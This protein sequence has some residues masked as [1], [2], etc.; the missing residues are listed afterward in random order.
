[1][2]DSRHQDLP[3]RGS[4]GCHI[5]SADF[6]RI[7]FLNGLL[8]LAILMFESSTYAGS[9][10]PQLAERLTCAAPNE[11]SSVVIEVAGGISAAELNNYLD[12][13][14]ETLSDRRREGAL[15]L[16]ERA[17]AT[18]ADLLIYLHTLEETG[19]V[20]NI[21][22]HWLTNTI[23]VEMI[24]CNIALAAGRNDVIEVF[25]YPE[26]IPIEPVIYG[27]PAPL[28]KTKG[29]NVEENLK[30]IGADSAWRMGYTGE[31]RIV[32]LLDF[33]GVEGK[34]PALFDNW[35]G[36]DGNPGAA[37]LGEWTDDGFPATVRPNAIHGTHIVGIM[38]G[39]D[40]ATGDTIGVAP[41]AEWI[42]SQEA[43][44]EF[45]ADPDGNPY[46][47]DDVPDVINIS[48]GT[49]GYCWDRYWDMIDMT[50]AFGIVNIISA[51]NRGSDPYS[52]ES[53]G[54]RALDS[55][56]NFAVGSIDHRSGLVWFSSSRGPSNCDSVSIKP[57]V[58]APGA[59]IRS[60]V[61][62]GLYAIMGGTSMAAPHVSGAVAILRQYAPNASVREIMQALLAGCTPRGYP[63]PNNDYGWGII[64]IPAS[65]DFLTSRAGPDLRVVDIDCPRVNVKDT[66]RA[67]LTLKNRGAFAD[68]V[69]I[70]FGPD[71]RGISLLNHSI[72]YGP[73]S[74]NQAKIGEIPFEAIFDDTIYAGAKIPIDYTIHGSNNYLRS[75]NFCIRA[76]REGQISTYTHK[77]SVLEFTVS[78]LGQY[79]N[80]KWG[81]SA[82]NCMYEASLMIG[83]DARHVVNN[84]RDSLSE[85][86]D[87]FWCNEGDSMVIKQEGDFADQETACIFD[88]GKAENRI[89]IQIKQNTFSWN[90]SPNNKYVLIEYVIKNI[91]NR[92]IDNI[93]IGLALDWTY[94]NPN[95]DYNCE[96]N[97]APR[98]NLGFIFKH[99]T[100]NDSS[101][102]RGMTV[103]NEE[104]VIS[105]QII[106]QTIDGYNHG[107]GL[108]DSAKYSALSGGIIDTG[109]IATGHETLLHVFSTGPFLL[110][111]GESDT[112]Y[113]AIL[114]GDSLSELKATARQA[115]KKAQFLIRQANLPSEVTLSQ[116]YPNPFN[117]STR[118]EFTTHDPKK[119]GLKIFN[120][121]GQ[122][123]RHFEDIVVS[124]GYHSVAW[125]GTDDGRNHVASGVY[126]YRLSSNN[127]SITRKMILLK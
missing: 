13:T 75:G 108:S 65:I 31:G 67:D 50:E 42:G 60:S 33:A 41:G 61:T 121:L 125:D 14:C 68:R 25:Q 124:P 58:T 43:D 93:I 3:M 91:S 53:P 69:Y 109:I 21:K 62:G 89:G 7:L 71:H 88:D 28:A 77:N 55:L 104:G 83:T 5:S 29:G 9:I 52:V 4:I 87:D 112:A 79:S 78:N 22:S 106:A 80:F 70:Q 127:S 82:R 85:P 63:H 117:S 59:F 11:I 115:R 10:N 114:G 126:F 46:T 122:E 23:D 92:V 66:L 49:S 116:N 6:L 113:F 30:F 47:T 38:V 73:I 111:P 100:E 105:Y 102:F 94:Q 17:R 44:W 98:E 8:Y 72:Y 96:M 12:S 74:L 45:A 34:H 81:D 51:G 1:M 16:Q 2:G 26:I 110:F 40:D 35:K 119:I 107:P 27:S 84:F 36:H 57:N 97:F 101:W 32:C 24:N 54:S 118:I 99:I 120:V 90:E 95:Y 48:F 64:N 19:Q 56:T 39:H 37:W 76:G 86:D 18:Q 15:L 20:K 103:L 123:V